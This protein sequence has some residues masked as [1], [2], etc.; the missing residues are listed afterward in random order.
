MTAMTTHRLEGLEPDNLLAF[1]AL[2]GLLRA[3]ETAAA[4]WRPRVHWNGPPLRPVLTLAEA[5]TQGEIA[6]AAARGCAELAKDYE[7]GG[8]TPCG[9][10]GG[11][12]L[13]LNI[14]QAR[15]LLEHAARPESRTRSDLLDA[16][17][18]DGALADD[19]GVMVTP[20]CALFGQG[21][22][23]FLS[24]LSGIPNGRMT[25]KRMKKLEKM[26]PRPDINGSQ[27]ISEALFTSWRRMDETDGF[28]WDMAEDRRYALR[29]RN[30]TKEDGTTTHGANRLA[31][32]GIAVL[33][34]AVV[35]RR[36]KLHFLVVGTEPAVGAIAEIRWPI[37]RIPMSLAALRALIAH[38]LLVAPVPDKE[39]L[40]RF[41]IEEVRSARHIMVNDYHN[42]TR[43]E[44]M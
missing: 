3:L 20:F 29:F 33:P 32:I 9:S 43:A 26:S 8:L 40:S 31:A 39:R 2:L 13:K 5:V 6:E 1:L 28:R 15:Q 37:C 18:S 36:G 7:F 14:S 27:M 19:G 16:L 12:D 11:V 35:E 25:K 38:P 41:G 23:H 21:H 30:P 44:A 24:R 34:G 10:C 42:F 4:D 22:Q 17:F